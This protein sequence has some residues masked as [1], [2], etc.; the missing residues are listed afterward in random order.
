MFNQFNHCISSIV[1]TKL[2]GLER[3]YVED[4]E[5]RQRPLKS[6]ILFFVVRSSDLF[7]VKKTWQRPCQKSLLAFN[8]SQIKVL[9]LLIDWSIQSCR[10]QLKLIDLIV[11]CIT[12]RE[13]IPYYQGPYK[14]PLFFFGHVLVSGTSQSIHQL[15]YW[16]LLKVASQKIRVTLPVK[17][18][19]LLRGSGYQP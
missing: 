8:E 7:F 3:R 15:L 1:N 2:E 16:P 12:Y 4:F 14:K 19:Y 18:C 13:K 10:Q 17:S 11:Y 9:I 6:P 5:A